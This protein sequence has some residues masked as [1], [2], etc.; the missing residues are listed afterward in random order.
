MNLFI[1]SVF[2]LILNEF[3]ISRIISLIVFLNK[4]LIFSSFHLEELLFII[5]P[6]IL[7][8]IS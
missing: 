6:I 4:Y 8:K 7:L 1:K 3:L 2:F 5:T